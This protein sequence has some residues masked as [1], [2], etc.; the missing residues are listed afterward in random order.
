MKKIFANLANFQNSFKQALEN[1]SQYNIFAQGKKKI[2]NNDIN[3]TI[4]L[5]FSFSKDCTF[6]F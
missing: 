4:F 3:I 2:K 5:N 6:Q 1:L